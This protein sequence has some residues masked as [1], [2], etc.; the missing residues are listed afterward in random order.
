M[1]PKYALYAVIVKIVYKTLF[2]EEL[3]V[4]YGNTMLQTCFY[5]EFSIIDIVCP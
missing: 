5:A 3:R 1:R 4:F 2:S